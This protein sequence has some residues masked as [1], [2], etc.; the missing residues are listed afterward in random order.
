MRTI[1]GPLPCNKKGEIKIR[2]FLYLDIHRLQKSNSG[3]GE[4]VHIWLWFGVNFAFLQW[5]VF[6]SDGQEQGRIHHKGDHF[7]WYCRIMKEY[8]DSTSVK[9]ATFER[10]L[11][12]Y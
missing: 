4:L 12:Q 10:E 6:P 9:I 7:V 5:I 1:C 3:G 11:R 2:D 8:C